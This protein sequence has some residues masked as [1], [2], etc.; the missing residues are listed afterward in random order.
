LYLVPQSA[1]GS[2]RLRRHVYMTEA[3]DI[4]VKS[5]TSSQPPPNLAT[6][7][8]TL[9]NHEKVSLQNV[10]PNEA[11]SKAGVEVLVVRSSRG[12]KYI[13]YNNSTLEEI[14]EQNLSCKRQRN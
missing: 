9:C 13:D 6:R 2:C 5:L 4:S 10:K 8:Y 1:L 11:P 3:L 7:D 14:E 12:S